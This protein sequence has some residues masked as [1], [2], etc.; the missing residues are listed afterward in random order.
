MS[1][2]TIIINWVLAGIITVVAYRAIFV[3]GEFHLVLWLALV[4]VTLQVGSTFVSVF[5]KT[6]R[7]HRSWLSNSFMLGYWTC[8]ALLFL[9]LL[10]RVNGTLQQ[11][12]GSPY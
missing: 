4:G 5:S 11:L 3:A 12:K 2:R 8:M 1:S 6:A 7:S 10:L 9:F